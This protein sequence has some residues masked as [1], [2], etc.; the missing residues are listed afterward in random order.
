MG[1]GVIFDKKS[2][3]SRKGI[4]PTQVKK[5]KIMTPLD[6]GSRNDNTGKNFDQEG[7]I[8]GKTYT[9]QVESYTNGSPKDK[10]LIK[11]KYKYHSL[12]QN[13]WIEVN[14][15]K[16]GDT[17]SIYM[18]E[19]DICGRTL[20]VMAYIND[21][22][23]E[24]YEKVWHHN[25]FRWFDRQIVYKQAEDRAKDPW[26]IN[27]ESSSLCGMAALY[28]TLIKKDPNL[29]LKIVKELFRTG[30]CRLNDFVIKPHDEALSMYNMDPRSSDYRTVSMPYVDWI[31]LATTRSRES[32]FFDNLVYKGVEKGSMDMIKA[33]NWPDMMKKMTQK[34]AGYANVNIIGLSKILIQQ[35]KRPL[36]GRIYDA[37]SDSDF[38]HLKDM[39]SKYEQGHKIMMMIDSNMIK[40][41]K[42]YS[43]SDIFNNSH[44]VVYE[45][46]L[47]FYDEKN[48]ITTD[49]DEVKNVSFK[50]YTWGYNPHDSYKNEGGKTPA[51]SY[52]LLNP[53]YKI[54]GNCFKSTFY[55]YIEMY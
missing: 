38:Q 49:F 20:H 3:I 19:K 7:M 12:S 31:V 10:K 52:T 44:W 32:F 24:G 48:N 54:S 13:K 15:S 51:P 25:R 33:V 14:S 4:E 30:E 8:F 47:T 22:K 46:G 23:S 34:V 35:K 9:F 43:Y 29:Y 40:N 11:W 42:S 28:Y 27:Q 41:V 17:Y 37:F 50:I 55:G 1:T 6:K 18:N 2:A 53:D 45:G 16:T 26:K 36:G 5:I 39:Q 21:E